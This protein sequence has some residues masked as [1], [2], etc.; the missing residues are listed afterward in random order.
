MEWD[1]AAGQALVELMGGK[2]KN[3][4]FNRGKFRL[5]EGLVYKKP[6]YENNSFIAY[7]KKIYGEL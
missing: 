6:D 5:G 4:I 7:G 3:L 1:S 2:V